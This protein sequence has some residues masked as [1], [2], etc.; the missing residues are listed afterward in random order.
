MVSARWVMRSPAT[1][2]ETSMFG[3]TTRWLAPIA[4]IAAVLFVAPTA[5]ASVSRPPEIQDFSFAADAQA[6]PQEGCD[7]DVQVTGSGGKVTQIAL[8]DGR[9]FNA[10]KGVLLTYTGNGKSYTVKTAGSVAKYEVTAD[11]KIIATYT[12]HNGIVFFSNDAG[13]PGITQYTGKIVLTLVNV[14]PESF[15]IESIDASAGRAVDVCDALS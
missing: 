12:G 3:K 7:F 15:K 10:G 8:Q 2:L 1:D 9:I 14:T 11:G 5:G 4:A 6:N 13:G